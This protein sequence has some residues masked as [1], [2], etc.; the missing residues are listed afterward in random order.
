MIKEFE[1]KDI[2]NSIDSISK[3]DKKKSNILV[4]KD[5]ND[6]VETNPFLEEFSAIRTDFP[7]TASLSLNS[8]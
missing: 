5:N 3:I 8:P 6:K 4:K 1:I 2:L 7:I